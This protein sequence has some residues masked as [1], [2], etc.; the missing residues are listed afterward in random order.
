MLTSCADE[1][2]DT[3]KESDESLVFSSKTIEKSLDNCSPEEGECTFISLTYPVA[4]NGEE[5]DNINKR[6]VE[7]LRN[8]IDYQE[9]GGKKSPKE[10]AE[11]F[12]GNY[13]ETAR[14]FP[15]YELPWEATVNGKLVYDTP[16]IIC[17]QFNTDMFTGG[18]HGYTSTDYLNFDPES[19]KTLTADDLF[20]EKFVNFV[21]KDFRKKQNIPEDANINSTGML[22]ENDRFHLPK[23]IGIT[24]NKVILHYNAYEIAPYAEGSFT[25]TYPREEIEEFLKLPGEND[26]P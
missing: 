13:K 12:I 16:K 11:D 7:F 3:Q 25:L 20:T 10:L 4:K 6:I 24:K 5:A 26:Q 19:G 14:E 8:T 23:N 21:E 9:E 18:A 17:L 1:P 2:K 15:E 22:F